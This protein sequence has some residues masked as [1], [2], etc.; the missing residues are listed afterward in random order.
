MSK[1]KK[2][3]PKPPATLRPASQ[4]LAEIKAVLDRDGIQGVQGFSITAR[5]EISSLNL[6]WGDLK[7]RRRTQK[8]GAKA[9]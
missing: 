8:T 7:I 3:I 5:T 9:V 2:S 1:Q 4:V 6:S